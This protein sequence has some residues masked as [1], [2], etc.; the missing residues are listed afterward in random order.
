MKPSVR[1]RTD[2]VALRLAAVGLGLVALVGVLPSS[3][4]AMAAPRAVNGTFVGK[5]AGTDVLIAVVAD[6][7]QAGT[8]ARSVRVYFCDDK[9]TFQWFVGDVKGNT[10]SL[11]STSKDATIKV[12]LSATSVTGRV[13]LPRLGA[14]SVKALA[15]KGV[16]GL[17][18]GNVTKD[19][20]VS[21]RSATGARIEG[22]VTGPSTV[23]GELIPV[24]GQPVPFTFGAIEP[25]PVDFRLIVHPSGEVRGARA[26]ASP[27]HGFQL[28]E[29]AK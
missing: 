19:G 4:A 16:A 18:V 6:A 11:S 28:W 23:T 10:V 14:R 5:L 17:Y 26:V 15:A 9:Q 25:V 21:G 27:T 1:I 12:T 29:P 3:P 20:V 22:T 7:L 13:T 8:S 24:Q 2:R